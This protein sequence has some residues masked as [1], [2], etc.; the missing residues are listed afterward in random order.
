MYFIYAYYIND[1]PL[2][3]GK[4][5]FPYARFRTHVYEDKTF[6]KVNRIDLCSINT[7]DEA[8]YYEKYYISHFSPS[9]NKKDVIV[10]YQDFGLLHQFDSYSI[11]EFIK[12][13]KNYKT[14]EHSTSHGKFVFHDKTYPSEH[15]FIRENIEGYNVKHIRHLRNK[16]MKNYNCNIEHAYELII[17]YGVDYFK[18]NYDYREI[19]KFIIENQNMTIKQTSEALG[20]TVDKVKSRRIDLISKGLLS[21]KN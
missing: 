1:V 9:N 21:L 12:M 6:E 7:I 4:T 13:F 2:Y 20:I 11:D 14:N 19:D 18:K 16:V 5:K 15:Q 3:V 10:K 17:E 8:K